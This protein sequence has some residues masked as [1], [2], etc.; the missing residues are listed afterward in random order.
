MQRHAAHLDRSHLITP[1]A[2]DGLLI[3]VAAT[4][5]TGKHRSVIW[6]PSK[7][8]RQMALLLITPMLPQL[9]YEMWRQRDRPASVPRLR[10]L[11]SNAVSSRLFERLFNR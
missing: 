7:T 10:P 4:S 9:I 2:R 1:L 8:R 11:N 5:R 3:H 6:Y